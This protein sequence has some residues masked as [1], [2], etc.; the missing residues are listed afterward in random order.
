MDRP[1]EV[2]TFDCYGTLIDG[3]RGLAAAFAAAAAADGVALDATAA[4]RAYARQIAVRRKVDER[5][6]QNEQWD[7]QRRQRER[8]PG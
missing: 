2:I 1:Y 4:A 7:E 5:V 3:E 6:L 8:P